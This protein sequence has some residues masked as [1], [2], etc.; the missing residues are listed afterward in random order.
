MD[1]TECHSPEGCRTLGKANHHCQL[2]K[3]CGF[4]PQDPKTQSADDNDYEDD[5]PLSMLA[6]N[7]CAS[8]GD[9]DDEAFHIFME[10][11]DDV[12]TSARLTD[13]GIIQEVQSSSEDKD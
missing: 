4:V 12:V 5:F 8:G 6:A 7:L 11:D 3:H 9:V 2:L 10:V 13:D 1:P